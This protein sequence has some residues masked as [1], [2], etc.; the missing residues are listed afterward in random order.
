MVVDLKFRKKN[1][2]NVKKLKP[3]KRRSKPDFNILKLDF[4]QALKFQWLK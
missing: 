2:T 4:L 3:S 1:L